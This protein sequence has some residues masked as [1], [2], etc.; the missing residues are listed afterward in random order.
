MVRRRLGEWRPDCRIWR[1]DNSN[2]GWAL[3]CTG[4]FVWPIPEK[5]PHKRLHRVTAPTLILW[6]EDDL[7]VPAAYANEFGAAIAGSRAEIVRDA[8]HIPQAE[9][10]ETTLALV[11][12]FL[13]A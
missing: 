2:L 4:T 13:S 10:M 6:G 7:L 11:R 3:G 9:Q 5:G 12:D 8:G 1:D